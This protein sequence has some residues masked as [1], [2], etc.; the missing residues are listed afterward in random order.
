[1]IC[2]LMHRFGVAAPLV[3]D[4]IE[5]SARRSRTW[6]LRQAAVAIVRSMARDL[7]TARSL[8]LRG[9]VLAWALNRLF[10]ELR[11]PVMMA[12]GSWTFPLD[13]WLTQR[14]SIRIPVSFMAVEFCSAIA[15]GWLV[16]RLH[17]PHSMAIVSAY[18]ATLLMVFVGGTVN[19]FGRG[20][21]FDAFGFVANS[22]FPFVVVPIAVLSG[23]LLVR[24]DAFRTSGE[25][26]A[27]R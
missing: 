3:G 15:I 18:V 21:G 9:L 10:A 16:S 12:T 8:A 24:Q 7:A 20:Y 27:P 11:R 5:A 25:R 2:W 6:V 23:G 17:R 26:K 14:L 13:L 19:S 1:M 4:L 22:L